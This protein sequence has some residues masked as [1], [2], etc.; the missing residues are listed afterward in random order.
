MKRALFIGRFQPFHNGH[1]WLFEQKLDKGVPILVLVRDIEPDEKNPFTTDQTVNMIRRVYAGKGDLVKVMPIDDIESVNY[2]RGVG[3]EVNEHVP[4]LGI[5]NIS[6][7]YI[8]D[9][10]KNH[11]D[12]WKEL[13]DPSI[14]EL[15]VLH[16]IE[17]KIMKM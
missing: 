16:L 17:N 15:V 13:V 6:A 11:D 1:K 12:S 8:R 3:Y 2:G 10:I 5:A 9:C 4:P 7:T 14:H